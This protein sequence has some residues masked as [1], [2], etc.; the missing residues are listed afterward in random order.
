MS[1]QRRSPPE[2]AGVLFAV[3][4]HPRKKDKAIVRISIQFKDD[5]AIMSLSGRF[6]AGGDGPFLRQKV[7]ELAEAGTKLM[8]LNF[9]NVPY[10]DSTGLGFLVGSRVTAEN[11]GMSMV[12]AGI[13][14]HVKKILDSVKLSQFFVMADD[15]NAALSKVKE[16]ETSKS[17]ESARLG[18]G[19][20]RTTDPS[21]PETTPSE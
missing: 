4:S 13:N 5:V 10:I 16:I 9:S 3:P 19:K 12:L 8:V 2:C 11:T 15:E 18:K 1:T 17:G 7:K 14:P 21:Q 6:L 20:K